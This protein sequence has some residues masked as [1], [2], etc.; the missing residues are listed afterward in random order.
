MNNVL[1]IEDVNDCFLESTT[2][3]NNLRSPISVQNDILLLFD[4]GEKFTPY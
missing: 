1:L 2:K 4:K 3:M